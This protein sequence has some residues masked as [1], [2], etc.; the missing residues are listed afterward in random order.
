MDLDIS[1]GDKKMRTPFKMDAHDQLLL[2][3]GVSRQLDILSYHPDVQV[4]RGQ[5]TALISEFK[6]VPPILRLILD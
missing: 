5:K 2:F 3:E 6:I 1:F 4:W